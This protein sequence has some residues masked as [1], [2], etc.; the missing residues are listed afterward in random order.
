[1]PEKYLICTSPS[2]QKEMLILTRAELKLHTQ[3]Q[4]AFSHGLSQCSFGGLC[5]YCYDCAY[6]LEI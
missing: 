3:L 5:G 4:D 2:Q 1:M 6:R